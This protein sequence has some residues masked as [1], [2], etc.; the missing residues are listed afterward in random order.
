M[1]K[2]VSDTVY[3]IAVIVAV[4]NCI[5]FVVEGSWTP[6]LFFL[7]AT[8]ATFSVKPDKTLALVTGI[9]VSNLYRATAGVHE[10]MTT[11]KST[12]DLVQDSSDGLDEVATQTRAPKPTAAKPKAKSSQDLDVETTVS[13]PKGE[14]SQDDEIERMMGGKG[15]LE[16]L[17]AR[18]SKL[19]KNLKDMQPM[20]AQAKNM[21]NSLPKGFVK[22]ALAQ[23]KQQ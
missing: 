6:L 11:S 1:A 3:Y 13:K 4:F 18:Q 20:M 5:A 10:G 15:S 7:L 12:R 2:K 21:L 17:M 14:S 22:Q 8:F 16:G 9:V 19:M 23:F